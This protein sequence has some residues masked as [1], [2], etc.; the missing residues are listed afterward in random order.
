MQLCF[1]LLASHFHSDECDIV[2]MIT[3]LSSNLS[4]SVE[5]IMESSFSTISNL[6]AMDE[7]S[8]TSNKANSNINMTATFN[9]YGELHLTFNILNKSYLF[10]HSINKNYK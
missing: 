5:K 6:D 10:Q 4:R 3:D 8:A 7:N 1:P 9:D 2:D